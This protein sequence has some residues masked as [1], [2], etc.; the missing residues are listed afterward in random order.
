MRFGPGKRETTQ[1]RESSRQA[2]PAKAA[3]S[4]E[5]ERTQGA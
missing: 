3:P 5:S 1:N 2:V 4:T